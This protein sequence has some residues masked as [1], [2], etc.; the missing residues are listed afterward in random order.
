M[1]LHNYLRYQVQA[2]DGQSLTDGILQ[3]DQDVIAI[4]PASGLMT[5]AQ[6]QLARRA[7]EVLL[8]DMALNLPKNNNAS[9]CLNE[10]FD[11]INEYLRSLATDENLPQTT[12][13][14][15]LIALQLMPEHLSLAMLG[16]YSC[17]YFSAGELKPLLANS[18]HELGVGKDPQTED[19]EQAFAEGDQL[20]IGKTAELDFVDED[21]IR[22]TL[23]RFDDNL[24]MSLRQIS[25]RAMNQGLGYKPTMLLCRLQQ[26]AKK[27]SGWLARLRK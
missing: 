5:L 7:V 21:Y 2:S 23:G 25:A 27:A 4:N 17:L 8:D 16:S 20:L 19:C 12:Q 15:S 18:E 22:V 3:T 26:D 24:D 9:D 10:S 1:N 14:V 6:G 13:G 11:N